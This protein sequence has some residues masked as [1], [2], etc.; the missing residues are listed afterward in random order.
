MEEIVFFYDFSFLVISFILI[1]VVYL[2]FFLG[3]VGWIRRYLLD[4]Q[5]LEFVWTALPLFILLFLAFPSIRIL[6][7]M[8]EAQHPGLS[9]KVM[10]H[11][12]FWS[13]EYRDFKLIEFD[14]YIVHNLA[15][16]LEVDNSFVLPILIKVRLL[17]SS[18]DVLHSWTVPSLGVKVDSVPGRLNQLNFSCNRLGLFFGQCSEIC[19]ANHRFMPITVEVLTAAKF[20][21]WLLNFV[22]LKSL[23]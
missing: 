21:N 7:L 17:V 3:W 12:W 1:F 23:K 16:L 20:G 8:D 5:V 11:Q 6:Y 10:G 4:N 14:S 19:G 22:S 9:C 13:Y 15:R 2:I 18:F